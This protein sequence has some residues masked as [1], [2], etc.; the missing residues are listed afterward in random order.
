[1]CLLAAGAGLVTLA[2]CFWVA[3]G[4][5]ADHGIDL[6]RI[7][8]ITHSNHDV[9]GRAAVDAS[10]PHRMSVARGPSPA[11]TG[12]I[13]VVDASGVRA[14]FTG[15]GVVR[16]RLA[17]G[18]ELEA[19]VV[20]VER[21][22][23]QVPLDRG[24]KSGVPHIFFVDRVALLGRSLELIGPTSFSDT[25]ET[26]HLV[27]RWTS[28]LE[29][30]VLG[31]DAQ[32]PLSCVSVFVSRT[33][34]LAALASAEAPPPSDLRLE[35]VAEAVASPITLDEPAIDRAY[36][37]TA[38]G[39]GWRR[40]GFYDSVEVAG[41]VVLARCGA[42]SIH[43][44]RT[45]SM[46]EMVVAIRRSFEA[47][48]G[49]QW[50]ARERI[51]R[52]HMVIQ[53]IPPGRYVA[54]IERVHAQG[55]HRPLAARSFDVEAGADSSIRFDAAELERGSVEARLG[56]TVCSTDPRVIERVER[57]EVTRCDGSQTAP[58][59][60]SSAE[61]RVLGA[62]P[63]CME[64]PDIP[65]NFGRHRIDLAPLG[66]TSIVDVERA[67]TRITVDVPEL[68]DCVLLF[69]DTDNGSPVEPE[70]VTVSAVGA[71]APSGV[72]GAPSPRAERWI[73]PGSSLL[74]QLPAGVAVIS[75]AARSYGI[76]DERV[77]VSPHAPF[78]EV[79]VHPRATIDIHVLDGAEPIAV[80][81]EWARRIVLVSE[82][83]DRIAVRGRDQT[84]VISGGERKVRTMS[85]LVDYEGRL[86]VRPPSLPRFGVV[87]PVMVH[88][89]RGSTVNAAIAVHS[90]LETQR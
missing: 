34:G 61:A 15:E 7:L 42:V 37:F 78:V 69:V 72:D 33:K 57:L 90:P 50:F 6:H 29:F 89:V 4:T 2:T 41:C 25:D 9:E 1:V 26:W 49:T 40:V 14:A 88:A 24:W 66:L 79:R 32:L 31:G 38:P 54:S 5:D 16:G 70:W 11:R 75:V 63:K 22:T 67:I 65:V 81:P 74:V 18:R 82:S 43:V 21:G 39:H 20:A 17:G 52:D 44:E 47:D 68:V 27:G 28:R 36:W 85:L 80:D 46:P 84:W 62:V 58:V 86:E 55:G 30:A 10:I 71:G 73:L 45:T 13:D 35:S 59:G 76:Q 3:I 19:L 8:P 64:W 87:A 60:F 51:D 53:G 56:V 77:E 23:W 83:G 12:T 48:R